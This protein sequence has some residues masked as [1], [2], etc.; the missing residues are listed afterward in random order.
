MINKMKVFRLS[1]KKLTMVLI[2]ITGALAI[3]ACSKD[4]KETTIRTVL[5]QVYNCP[6][7]EIIALS[8]EEPKVDESKLS[9]TGTGIAPI[10]EGVLFDKIEE[11]Y[12]PYFTEEAYQN[13]LNERV[14]YGYHLDAEENG[15][16]LKVNSIDINKNKTDKTKYDFTI[17]L[18]Y[19]SEAG[20]EKAV[21]IQGAAQFSE[22]GKI[23]YL[24]TFSD[25]DKKLSE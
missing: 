24:K 15:Y 2:V 14:P 3:S 18:K 25:L 9:E 13:L 20:E 23:N 17:H 1:A 21:D 11:L 19:T 16:T 4:E 6:D 7:E 8:K 5:E 12:Q 10:V 22:D